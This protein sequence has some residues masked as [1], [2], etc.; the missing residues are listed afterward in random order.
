MPILRYYYTGGDNF[1][2]DEIIDDCSIMRNNAL[3]M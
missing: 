3:R 2:K 1:E